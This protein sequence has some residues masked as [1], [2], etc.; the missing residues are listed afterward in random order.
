MVLTEVKASNW[1][2]ER[3][4]KL[5]SLNSP[6]IELILV[7]D[8]LTSPP[9][10]CE[11]KFPLTCCGPLIAIVPLAVLPMMML[12]E[13]VEQSASKLASAWEFTVTVG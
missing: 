12:P 6:P 7:L 8:K 10:L 13:T 2:V 1:R 3:K 11:V 5:K 9:A 4:V